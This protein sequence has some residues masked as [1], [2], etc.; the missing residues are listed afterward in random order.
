MRRKEFYITDKEDIE[1]LLASATYGVLGLIDDEGYPY[2]VP[3]NFVY[4]DEAIYAHGAATP[5]SKKIKAI[6]LNN[7]ASFTVVQEYSVIPSYFSGSELACPASQCFKSV[8]I[9]GDVLLVDDMDEKIASLS[10]LMEKLQ[11]TGGYEPITMAIGEYAKELKATAVIKLIPDT[12][13]AKF[14]FGQARKPEIFEKVI[15]E[16]EK[17]GEPIDMETAMM[18][19]K[20]YPD[21]NK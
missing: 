14:K 3:L 16:L 10:A 5:K 1:S 6:T 8:F 15:S 17:R 11:P 13:T 9:R 7:K 12:L 21:K 19:R 18:M 4:H 2:T 20:Y